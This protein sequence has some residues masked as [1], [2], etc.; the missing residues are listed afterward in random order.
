MEPN[1]F[2]FDAHDL[3]HGLC[4]FAALVRLYQDT[5][6]PGACGFPRGAARRAV[7][8]G[9]ARVRAIGGDAGRASMNRAWGLRGLADKLRPHGLTGRLYWLTLL[10]Y[11]WLFFP[12]MARKL[13]AGL[14]HSGIPIDVPS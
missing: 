14:R 9:G 4:A 5:L 7:R 11:D 13:A 8:R 2:G 1:H 3:G 12:R 10:P 6:T